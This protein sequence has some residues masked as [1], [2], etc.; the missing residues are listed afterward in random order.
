MA[1]G[2]LKLGVAGA[3]L[4][5]LTTSAFAADLGDVSLKDTPLAGDKL[6][7]TAN[8]GLMSDYIFRGTSQN[9]RDP[10]GTAG[11]DLAYGMFYACASFEGVK[12]GNELACSTR[13]SRIRPVCGHQAEAQHFHLR[14]RH[15]HLQLS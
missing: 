10:S 9:G 6:T 4:G 1:L 8:A 13:A 3:M 5:M 15:R 14:F 2:G 12:F 11:V 7:W